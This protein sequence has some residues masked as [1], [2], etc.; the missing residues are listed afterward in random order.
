MQRFKS[1]I[2]LGLFCAAAAVASAQTITSFEVA[3]SGT[4]GAQGTQVFNINSAGTMVGAYKDSSSLYHAFIRTSAGVDTVF[5]DPNGVGTLAT[6]I[7]TAGVVS[8]A[9][10]D[11]GGVA[12]GIV[13]ATDGTLT[14]FDAARAGTSKGEGTF[15]R[16]INAGGRIV[17][18]Y[19]DSRGVSHG[20]VRNPSTGK[21]AEFSA[22]GAGTSKGQGTFMS[23]EGIPLLLNNGPLINTAGASV[24]YYV[25][26][27]GA[28]HGFVRAANGTITEFD[29]TG[30]G[31]AKSEGTVASGINATGT[32]VGS[33]RDSGRVWHGF[34]RATD[35]TITEFDATT[36]GT[37]TLAFGINDSGAVCGVFGN[38]SINAAEGFVRAADGT[39]TT[40]VAPDAGNKGNG[41]G[42]YPLVVNDAGDVV[43]F[44]LDDTQAFHGFVRTP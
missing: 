5:D 38:T 22:A 32:I 23:F 28:Y 6:G 34:I 37:G 11:S 40:F 31:T 35:G 25:D 15:P 39:F 24:G 12:H 26:G 41:Q 16:G 10:G 8:G 33:Y 2:Q 44:V 36:G 4:G 43:G 7:N 21:I 1:M 13:R 42:T 3:G 27:I 29:A 17:G 19:Y 9:Y 30:A 14:E 18:N 20:F